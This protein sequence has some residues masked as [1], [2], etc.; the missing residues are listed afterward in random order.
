MTSI[1]IEGIDG[2]G[3]TT[4]AKTLA[5]ELNFYYLK[6]PTEF[7]YKNATKSAL[8]NAH[9]HM[10]D[11]YNNAEFILIN[12]VVL[13]RYLPSHL[14]YEIL[15]NGGPDTKNWLDISVNLPIPNYTFY[16]NIDV[17]N[18][19]KRLE[20]RKTLTFEESITNLYLVQ[21]SYKNVIK[22]L[23]NKQWNI[24]NLN[25]NKSIEKNL[26]EILTI[27]K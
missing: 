16:L 8:A 9:L 1:L 18:V 3:K 2:S 14:A 27:L 17:K 15:T 26:Y 10:V 20:T 19:W 6:F 5:E 13:D 24:C 22:N 21:Q 25:G 23:E 12:N 4:L 11:F 7:Y